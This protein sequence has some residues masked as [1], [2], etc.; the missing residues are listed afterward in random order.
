VKKFEFRLA[1]VK[2]LRDREY[3]DA[4][5]A[6][7]AQQQ[8]L[9]DEQMKLKTLHEKKQDVRNQRAHY[10]SQLDYYMA[11]WA[12]EYEVGVDYAIS[13]QQV[14]VGEAHRELQN[15]KNRMMEALKQKKIFEKLE[16]KARKEYK[17]EREKFEQKFF[18]DIASSRFERLVKQ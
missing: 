16:D 5:T 9:K 13:A 15:R 8:V 6:V 3:D 11:E 4:E 12:S 7:I 17:K 1:T 18:D 14:R 2:K 10:L